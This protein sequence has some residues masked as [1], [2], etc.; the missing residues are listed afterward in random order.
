MLVSCK[1]GARLKKGLKEP[2]IALVPFRAGIGEPTVL[3]SNMP[4]AYVG[5][6]TDHGGTVTVGEPTVL[7]G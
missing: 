5:S 4:A 7:V 3:M 1:V 2:T 6:V